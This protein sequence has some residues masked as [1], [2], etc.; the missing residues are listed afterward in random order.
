M[1]KE[2]QA[3]VGVDNQWNNVKND[4]SFTVHGFP[5][6]D[7]EEVWCE[8][9]ADGKTGTSAEDWSFEGKQW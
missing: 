7:D 6:G 9:N 4:Q 5:Y 8:I 2:K 3:S 1:Q